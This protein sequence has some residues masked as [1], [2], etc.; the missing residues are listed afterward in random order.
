MSIDLYIENSYK[1]SQLMT[2]E[3][4]TSFYMASSLLDKE[5]RE[6]I[7]AIYGFVRLADEIVDSFHGF[8]KAF[9][10]D[11]LTT[12]LDYA[13][14]NNISANTILM[15]FAHTVHKH[16]IDRDHIKA[17]MDSMRADLIK[18]KYET[19]QDLEHYIYGSA[20]VVG[21][22]CLKVFCRA[23]KDLYL[24]LESPAQKLGSAFQKVNFL[25]DLKEDL[26]DLGRV[27]FPELR[28]HEFNLESKKIIEASIQK[29]F[30]E[31]WLGIVKLPGRSK[32]A[33]ALAY[34]YY[35]SLFLK[36]KKMSPQVVLSKRIRISDFRKYLIILKVALMYKIRAF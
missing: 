31:A 14:K 20:N 11:K 6:S 22:M 30:E 27:Y 13:L 32:L 2:K 21:L 34:F 8:D 12:D 28:Q 1:I 18:S 24:Q 25:R 15:A 36:I 35:W 16:E 26:N 3:Y 5:S 23:N 7:Y 4:S 33:V 17:F 29:D 19:E 9:L 10:L